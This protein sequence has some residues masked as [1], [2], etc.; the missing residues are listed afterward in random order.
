MDGA[1]ARRA[2]WSGWSQAFD[3]LSRDKRDTL[4][5]L[6]T[7]AWVLAPHAPHLP[8]WCSGGAALALVWRAQLAWRDAPLP[9]RWWLLLLLTAAMAMTRLHYASLIGR[10]S[11][12]ALVVILTA[13]KSLELRARRDALV[14]LYLGFFLIF[15]EFL[16]GQ[17]LGTAL[18]MLVGV[19][20]LL[21]A[22]VMGQRP[23]GRAP[24]REVGQ[25][26]AKAMVLGLPTM[27]LLFLL[28]PRLGPL[29]SAPSDGLARTGLQESIVLGQ[30]ADL[31]QDDSI[32]MR[33]T[34]TGAPPPP[35]ALYFRGPT[36]D[37]FDGL[38]WR[39]APL[40]QQH[41]RIEPKGRAVQYELTLEPMTLKLAP[42]LEGTVQAVVTLPS[43][44][45]G[46]T[47]QGLVWRQTGSPDQ[48]LVIRAQAWPEAAHVRDLD[49]QAAR[50]WLFL[51]IGFNPRTLMWAARQRALPPY[52]DG[53]VRTLATGVLEHIRTGNYRY[54]IKPGLA[55]DPQT[56]HLIDDFWL[57]RQA[58]FCEHFS[59]AFVVVMRAMGVPARVVTGFQGAEYNPVDGQ[60]IVRNSQA[61]AWAE[62]WSPGEGWLRVDPTAAVAPE[63][64]ELPP[65]PR[66]LALLPGHYGQ[67]DAASL[68]RLRSLWE[69]VDHR[70]NV[71]V[72]Q[73][74]RDQQ[75]DVLRHLG[76]S[77]PDWQDLGQTLALALSAAGLG[78]SLLIWLRREKS[79]RSPWDRPLRQLHQSLMR[80]NM[81][82]PLGIPPSPASVWQVHLRQGWTEP[83]SLTQQ[84]LLT[85]LDEFD[86]LRYGLNQKSPA[87]QPRAHRQVLARINTLVK[88]LAGAN[89]SPL[90][91]RP[92]VAR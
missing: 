14:C 86:A 25:V 60:F 54:T 62:I 9:S 80:L 85:S 34:F 56:P 37:D 57:D 44:G 84:S 15:T 18:L 39:S 87:I 24:L 76:W 89:S 11:G 65:A 92:Q 91:P 38:T 48:R 19:W 46:L 5:L 49:P 73:Y 22:L 40:E 50:R 63:R 42:L 77:S 79:T 58:G 53:D 67:I 66:P 20:G 17:G 47:H 59:T 13:L 55:S 61:H 88:A 23:L 10:E 81:G 90:K 82:Q 28:F 2:W 12:I 30:V 72:L 3:R 41:E 33:L 70:W 8:W 78:A 21:T 36:L 68:R 75:M 6:A 1:H 16:Y 52:R 43:Q 45:V 32:A 74:N 64:I 4:W 7:L 31:A 69:A 29:W 71:W 83:L 51:P 27:L 26:S 35:K